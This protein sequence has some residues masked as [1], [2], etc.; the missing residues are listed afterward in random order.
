MADLKAGTTIGGNLVWT[1]GNFPLFPTGNKLLYK[2]FKVYTENDKPQ[3]IDND[4]VSKKDGGTFT[5]SISAKTLGVTGRDGTG[6]GISLYGGAQTSAEPQYGLHFSAQAN[7]GTHG[8]AKGTNRFATYFNHII[9]YP[10]IF[11]SNG[12]NVASINSAGELSVLN[13]NSSA[14]A[15]TSASHLTR[16]DYVDT[17]INNITTNTN[18]RVLRTG[19]TMTG[20]LTAP[21]IISTNLATSQ[22]HVPQLSQVVQRGI[23]LDYGTF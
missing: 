18:N 1:Q 14:S 19:D 9:E 8:V 12:V 6:D 23:V 11:R 16:K 7:Y 15:P 21:N 10:W 13:A 2:T 5:G 22:N 17:L 20:I 4:F 3:A